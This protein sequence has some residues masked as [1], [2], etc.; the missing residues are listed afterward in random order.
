MVRDNR[1]DPLVAR[2]HHLKIRL[3]F[4]AFFTNI[5]MS[6]MTLSH[7]CSRKEFFPLTMN[8]R[9]SVFIR[10]LLI[11]TIL[12]PAFSVAE[13]AYVEGEALVI[14]RP[15]VA[16]GTARTR[17]SGNS[18]RLAE[19]YDR[20]SAARGKVH[21]MVRDKS[22]TTAALIAEL[23]ADPTVESAEPNYIRKAFFIRPNDTYF[24]KQWG[25]ENSGQPA[26]LANGTPG[27]DSRFMQAWNLSRTTSPAQEIV[28][29]VA[30]TGVDITHPDLAPNIWTNPTEI[31]GNGIDD[32]NNGVIDDVHG[33]DFSLNSGTITDSGA[34]GTHVAGIIAAAGKNSQGVIGVQYKAKILPLKVSKDGNDM[35]SSYII[36][37]YNYA[38]A[39]KNR[40]V[41][42]VAY[43][44]SYGGESYSASEYNAINTM[45]NAGIVLCAAAGNSTANN[46]SIPVYP[47]NYNLSNIITVASINA[48]N[49]L[50]TFSN[51]GATTV[52]LGAPGTGIF[53]TSPLAVGGKEVSV[54]VG[55]TSYPAAPLEFSSQTTLTGMTRAIIHCGTGETAGDFPS[56]VNGNIALIRRGNNT[57]AAKVSLAMSAGAVGVIIY[58]NVD[59]D[60]SFT[61]LNSGSWI[62][63]VAITLNSGNAIQASL[64]ATGTI[65]SAP[66][67]NLPYQYMDGTSMA[68]PFVSGAVAFAA[69]NF[70]TDTLDQRINRILTHTTPVS[71]LVGKTIRGGR[72]DL[73]KMIDTDQDGLPDWWET[74]NFGS[75]AQTANADPDGDGYTNLQE[76]LSGTNP[77]SAGNHLAFSS[78]QRSGSELHLSFPANVERRYQI[79]WSDTL[80]PPWTALGS[81]VTGSGTILQIA[82]P[83]AFSTS[84]KRFYRLNLLPD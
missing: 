8:A 70:P 35:P 66:A 36:A 53:S 23:K 21:G 47:A 10:S 26:S 58:N 59:D 68:T 4:I 46:D 80:Q 72:L 28:V 71:A 19:S 22:R 6:A 39:M 30:D 37:A 11:L 33:F 76:F 78:I 43:N 48:R 81:P 18:R 41:N 74:E 12:A 9:C 67:P 25:I 45:R 24:S 44:A 75:L 29:C 51:Y 17:M 20:I 15:N 3:P 60:G 38:V 63:T 62:P 40:G 34:H 31:P 1:F 52:D 77:N 16:E 79:E 5:F 42:I 14:F 65:V 2:P 83:N 57:F 32:D 64:P 13:D 82:D 69:L 49:A 27:V 50:S 56:A 55:S 61:L 7:G 54:T 73:L 84:P